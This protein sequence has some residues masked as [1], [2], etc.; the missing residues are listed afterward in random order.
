MHVNACETLLRLQAVSG[1]F[2]GEID[3]EYR[4]F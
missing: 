1:R 4:G 2:P 3:G